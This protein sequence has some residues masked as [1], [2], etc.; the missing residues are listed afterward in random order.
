MSIGNYVF[1]ICSVVVNW[2]LYVEVVVDIVIY[3]K[4]EC[5]YGG[6][7]EIGVL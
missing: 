4:C 2:I 6:F 5:V 7:K 3:M 1:I